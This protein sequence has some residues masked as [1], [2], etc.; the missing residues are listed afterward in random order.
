[1]TRRIE[2]NAQLQRIKESIENY[3][4]TIEKL[5]T[6]TPPLSEEDSKKIKSLTT[7][8]DDY[9]RYLAILI[10]GYLE[11][12]IKEIT[13]DYFNNHASAASAY[14]MNTWPKGRNM[15]F[16]NIA[17]VI[18]N[19]NENK[20]LQFKKDNKKLKHPIDDLIYARNKLAHGTPLTIIPKN[21]LLWLEKSEEVINKYEFHLNS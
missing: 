19:V 8:I 7:S 15:W 17:Q 1:M 3:N 6:K 2:Y 11:T 20:G 21:V 13:E 5:E 16:D 18:S 14:I 9:S 12:C 4:S 10:S